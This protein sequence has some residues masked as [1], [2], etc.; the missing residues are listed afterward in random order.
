[1]KNP[2]V[3][4]LIGGIVMIAFVIFYALMAMALAQARIVQNANGVLQGLFYAIL[5]FSW[6]FPLLPLIKW[7][8]RKPQ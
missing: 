6:V 1:M 4:K 7:M 8:E 3:R 2:R 5:G